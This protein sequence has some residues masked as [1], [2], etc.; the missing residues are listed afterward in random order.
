MG[1]AS[2]RA[3]EPAGLHRGGLKRWAWLCRVARCL[4]LLTL[5][6]VRSSVERC[7]FSNSD[8]LNRLHSC[9]ART[10]EWLMHGNSVASSS[11]LKA[12][13]HQLTHF[14]RPNPPNKLKLGT[15]LLADVLL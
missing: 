10:G 4:V 7:T 15:V 8:F 6:S 1:T 2:S 11:S 14:V 5:G 3:E 12:Q 9:L 13:G